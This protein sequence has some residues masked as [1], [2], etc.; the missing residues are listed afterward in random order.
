MC[1]G[2]LFLIIFAA[3]VVVFWFLSYLNHAAGRTVLFALVKI[4]VVLAF[5]FSIYY[6]VYANPPGMRTFWMA[7][8]LI[9]YAA[10]WGVD[11]YEYSLRIR[12]WAAKHQFKVLKAGR[13][14]RFFSS[15]RKTHYRVRVR[16][17]HQQ[18][19]TYRITWGSFWGNRPDELS[20]ECLEGDDES[21]F[22]TDLLVFAG[23]H[24]LVV[25]ILIAGPVRASE[26]F[27][28]GLDRLLGDN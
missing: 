28:Q 22:L 4:L 1:C 7:C 18:Q 23:I 9:A 15:R 16:D 27:S 25:F 14:L 17:R 12:E 26:I 21:G 11:H 24:L 10:L 19:Y 8:A 20:D 5:A 2:N 13:C 6:R 3:G